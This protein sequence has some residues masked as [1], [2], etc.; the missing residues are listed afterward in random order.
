MIR[1]IVV[2]GPSGNGK[3]SLAQALADRLGWAMIEG[4]D[5]HPP[6]NIAK[7]AS[8]Q[9]LSDADR[10]PFLAAVGRA[11]AAHPHGA[12]AACS[13]L[14]RAY[15]DTLR[16][17]A[18]RILFVLPQVDRAALHQRMVA[19]SGHFMPA[20]LLDS[21]LADLEPPEADETA[22][23]IDGSRPVAELAANVIAHLD[24][25]KA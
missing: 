12:V 14:K 2:M 23:V 19:R 8:G 6:A 7:M 3:S 22:L 5:H 24:A 18:G 17:H 11:L 21:Q 15:R 4:D 20:A 25:M 1:A 9:P 10:R 13:A 16:Q